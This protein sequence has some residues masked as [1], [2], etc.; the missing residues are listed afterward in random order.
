MH[1]GERLW[2]RVKEGLDG[3]RA[4]PRPGATDGGVATVVLEGLLPTEGLRVVDGAFFGFSSSGWGAK[5][6]RGRR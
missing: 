6:R 1:C 4:R 2:I 5:G 3:P